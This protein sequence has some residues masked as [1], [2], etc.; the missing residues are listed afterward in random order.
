MDHAAPT[1]MMD[2]GAFS[3][4]NL[5]EEIDL[6]AY[7]QFCKEYLNELDYI[8]ALDVIPGSPGRHRI[9]AAEVDACCQQGWKNYQKMLRAGL[10]V[11]KVMPVFHQGDDFRW[12]ERFMSRGVPYFG[13]SPANDRTSGQRQSWLDVCMKYVCDKR[14][15]PL[16][17]FHGFAVTSVKLMRRYPWYSCDSAS[18]LRHAMYGCVVLPPRNSKGEWDYSG[19][20]WVVGFSARSSGKGWH[21]LRMGLERQKVLKEYLQLIGLS[22]GVSSYR[23]EPPGYKVQ[24]GVESI[25]L[26]TPEAWTVETVLEEGVSNSTTIRALANKIFFETV[27]SHLTWPRPFQ[28]GA[29]GLL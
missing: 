29:R 1:L 9:S 24:K 12:L 2:S 22:L 6:D 18:W 27:A 26:K 25:T 15:M 19:T 3:V 7:I 21:Y 13:I 16:A 28:F 10:P 14:G 4:W 5:G 17:K 11:E 23:T 20:P 8:V